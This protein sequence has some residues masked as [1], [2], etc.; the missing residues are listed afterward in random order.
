LLAL[1][2]IASAFSF[3]QHELHVECRSSQQVKSDPLVA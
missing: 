2:A 1:G 3:R